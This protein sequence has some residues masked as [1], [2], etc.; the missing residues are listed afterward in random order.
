MA[1][2]YCG[3][4][5][6][7]QQAGQIIKTNETG[8]LFLI[9]CECLSDSLYRIETIKLHLTVIMIL[10]YGVYCIYVLRLFQME[11]INFSSR[12]SGL[13]L[14]AGI[15]ESHPHLFDCSSCKSTYESFVLLTDDNRIVIKRGNEWEQYS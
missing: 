12:G 7:R 1:F 3:F 15:H 5:I 8:I 11:A 14:L 13:L 4:P 9:I 2:I 6:E 10:H